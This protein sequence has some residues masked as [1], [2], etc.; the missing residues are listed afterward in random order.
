MQIPGHIDPVVTSRAITP[1]ADG[2]IDLMGLS[3]LQIKQLFLESQL[4]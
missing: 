1:R 2:R 4:D 3:H